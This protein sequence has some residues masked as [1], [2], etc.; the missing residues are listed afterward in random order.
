MM[1]RN[2]FDAAWG[3]YANPNNEY[4]VELLSP[5]GMLTLQVC[6]AADRDTVYEQHKHSHY[7]AAADNIV[8]M[9]KLKLMRKY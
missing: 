4:M 2:H 7:V 6:T 8:T 9:P 1:I 5:S 3:D